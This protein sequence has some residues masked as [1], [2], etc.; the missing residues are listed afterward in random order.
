MKKPLSS[1]RDSS[2]H[3]QSKSWAIIREQHC[4]AAVALPALHTVQLSFS[5][6]AARIRLE[7]SNGCSS[8]SGLGLNSQHR[9][10]KTTA[11]QP[12]IH[13][14]PRQ[15]TCLTQIIFA[16][17]RSAG[18]AEAIYIFSEHDMM[19]TVYKRWSGCR[20]YS[21]ANTWQSHTIGQSTGIGQ[22]L[23]GRHPADNPALCTKRNHMGDAKVDHKYQHGSQG[24]AAAA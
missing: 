15:I 22:L 20:S 21:D 4:P 24:F 12:I 11:A 3:G 16:S 17:G 5:T 6:A 2:Q 8:S 14:A 10:I 18:R 1:A 23:C 13:M 7:L 9:L 19:F